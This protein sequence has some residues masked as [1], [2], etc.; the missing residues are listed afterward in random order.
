MFYPKSWNELS[1]GERIEEIKKAHE[2]GI[3][4]ATNI[5]S[6]LSEKLGCVVSR[7]MIT[8][9]YGRYR[10][11]LST[12]PLTGD[13]NG[14]SPAKSARTEPVKP[15]VRTPRIPKTKPKK[16]D[17]KRVVEEVEKVENLHEVKPFNLTLMELPNHGCRWPTGEKGGKILFCGHDQDGKSH[18]CQFH[19]KKAYL[20]KRAIEN[21]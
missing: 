17:V 9:Y 3:G 2:K 4:T 15:L 19:N 14:A 18:Y 21:A 10:M 20:P 12:H 13:N 1:T 5:A 7:G 6:H 8:G 11:A 16:K